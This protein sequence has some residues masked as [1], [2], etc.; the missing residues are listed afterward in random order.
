FNSVAEVFKERAIGI[1]LSGT[2]NDGSLGIQKIKE[3]GGLT[4]CQELKSAKYDGM[5]L[6]AKETHKIDLITLPSKMGT[7]LLKYIKNPNLYQLSSKNLA[8]KKII[9]TLSSRTEVDFFHY[10]QSTIERR[11]KK[12]LNTLRI[13]SY[14]K[15]LEYIE[16]NSEE[17]DYLL[18]NVL[19]GATSFFRDEKV[20]NSLREIV[21]RQLSLKSRYESIRV[22]VPGCATGEEVYS[23]AILINEIAKQS[24][25][26]ISLQIFGTD[27]DD[28]SLMIARN[29]IYLFDSLKSIPED[30]REKY[31]NDLGNGKY[32]VKKFLKSGIL[33]SK[34]DITSNPPFLKL[35]IISCRNL[36]V[37]FESL[38]QEKIL[39]VF[40][41]ALN[42]NGI[43]ILGKNENPKGLDEFLSLIHI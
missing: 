35:D 18:E 6:A 21:M 7:I 2:G 42:S 5:P 26:E 23:L 10:K 29:G 38:A 41:Y 33:F 22:W 30:L 39:A 28:A 15:Y 40:H 20:Y 37:Y 31:F 24:N 43:L 1:I 32:E 16:K 4:L 34:H 13:I 25:L 9:E 19:I 8:L 17:I 27:I 12:R 11:I 36:L 3:K 14:E